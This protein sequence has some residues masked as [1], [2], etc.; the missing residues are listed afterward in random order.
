MAEGLTEDSAQAGE[1]PTLVLLGRREGRGTK[2]LDRET[3]R[4]AKV[5]KDTR[6]NREVALEDSSKAKGH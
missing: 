2:R 3:T 6:V 5:E 1:A 4:R